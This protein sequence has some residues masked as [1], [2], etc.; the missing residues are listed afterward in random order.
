VN[1]RSALVAAG[2]VF[3][4][5]V[6]MLSLAWGLQHAA[7]NRPA[8]IGNTAP[9]LAIQTLDGSQVRVW[10]LRGKPVVVDFWASWCVSCAEDL[11]VL[12]GASASHPG[13]TFVGAAMQDTTGSVR[14]FEQRHPHP[15]AVGQ[16]VSGDYKA[17]GVFAPP[18]TFFIDAR[19]IVVASFAGPLDKQ[20]IDHYLGLIA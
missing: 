11:P 15:Y 14:D 1:R 8:V 6:L 16:I 3:L 9:R 12:A 13:I 18:V 7:A 2:A 4:G 17:Y 10:E 20:T 19:G 5:S